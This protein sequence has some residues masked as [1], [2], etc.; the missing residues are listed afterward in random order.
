MRSCQEIG[1]VYNRDMEGNKMKRLAVLNCKKAKAKRPCAVREMYQSSP[2]FKAMTNF[3]DHYYD[4]WVVISLKNTLIYPDQIIEPYELCLKGGIAS[5]GTTITKFDDEVWTDWATRLRSHKI[6]DEYDQVDF[7]VAQTP[8]WKWME[9]KFADDPKFRKIAL[10]ANTG[11]V[12]LDYRTHLQRHLDGQAVD[13]AAMAQPKPATSKPWRDEV[14]TW[15]HPQH[16]CF[17]GNYRDAFRVITQ[18]YNEGPDFATLEMVANPNNPTRSHKGW[19]IDSGLL[20]KMYYDPR[21]SCWRVKDEIITT[22]EK[23]YE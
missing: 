9:P 5:A 4:A 8:Y 23:F 18:V 15:S 17:Q 20:E 19:V 7:H 2:M 13:F 16:P 14:F 12:S 3:F 11:L 10:N 1:L 22:L 6:W 21:N